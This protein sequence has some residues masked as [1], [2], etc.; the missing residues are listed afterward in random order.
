MAAEELQACWNCAAARGS[1]AMPPDE[2][3]LPLWTAERW[4]GSIGISSVLAQALRPP[5]ETPFDLDPQAQLFFLKEM[6]LQANGKK[7]VH[8]L[9]NLHAIL[10]KLA[11]VIFLGAKT[12]LAATAASGEELNSKF[13]D[14]GSFIM[15]YGTLPDFFGGLESLIGSPNP[16]LMETM[17]D[18][19]MDRMDS[20]A[21]WTTGN[22]GIET[23]PRTEWMF[24]MEP[25]SQRFWPRETKASRHP[26]K[27]RSLDERLEELEKINQELERLGE[28]KMIKE[29]LIGLVLYTGPMFE[30][31]NAVNRGGALHLSQSERLKKEFEDNC[32]GNRYTT[33]IHVINSGII[34]LSKLTKASRVYRG[35]RQGLLPPQFWSADERGSRGG[36]EF[37]F[38]STTTSKAVALQYTRG[39]STPTV[40]EMQMGMIDRGAD[41]SRLSQYPEEREICFPPLTGM[42][43]ID[44]RVEGSVLV[45]QVRLNVNFTALTIDQ[46]LT[47]RHKVIKDMCENLKSEA[48]RELGGEAWEAY[49]AEVQ[50]LA[51]LEHDDEVPCDDDNF[52]ELQRKERLR[53]KRLPQRIREVQR[54]IDAA[55]DAASAKLVS[56]AAERFKAPVVAQPRGIGRAAELFGAPVLQQ[57]RQLRD[58]LKR[59]VLDNANN[60]L[61]A[62][63]SREAGEF[64]SD[65]V[66]QA[67]IREALEVAADVRVHRARALE[68]AAQVLGEASRQPA[69]RKIA[70]A[71]HMMMELPESE[72]RERVMELV[73]EGTADQVSLGPIAS[74]LQ[75]FLV[76]YG[77]L[78]G[79]KLELSDK[80]MG[81]GAACALSKFLVSNATLEELRLDYNPGLGKE[82]LGSVA[83][84]GALQ[85]NRTLKQL[86][87]GGCGISAAGAAALAGALHSN[88]SLEE[89]H[90]SVNPDVG[91]AGAA[92]LGEALRANRVL[93]VLWLSSCGVGDDGAR[94]LAAGLRGNH[95][96]ETL[97]L[98]GNPLL[99]EEG[100]AAL[101]VALEG[102]GVLKAL[103]LH[104]CGVAVDGAAAQ[105]LRDQL[106]SWQ[107]GTRQG[108]AL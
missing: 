70:R 2:T 12:L 22:Y 51:A 65:E 50:N 78:I 16:K 21:K 38:M 4:F 92:A 75:R 105:R 56:R 13:A 27:A 1:N 82:D 107:R 40:L 83:L 30:K 96:L 8:D 102:T 72:A 101:A 86:R 81:Q 60:K 87:L 79:K 11:D 100:A 69:E 74:A 43:V 33:T 18:E 103:W 71:I 89:L 94:A 84:A 57:A 63:T 36:V 62:I 68:A 10:G 61:D 19:H 99:G 6:A 37:G 95:T 34:K 59:L 85:V 104:A 46:V 66:L 91:E 45:V 98:A 49:F 26:R 42:E 54:R 14:S 31:Y 88:A 3:K 35:M 67:A 29:E 39:G 5:H 106:G 90:L 44:T 47:K 53:H 55:Q 23:C 7:M 77:H 28:V 76:L 93:K 64:N 20:E 73:S 108:L 58:S 15:S 17:C 32:L 52:F 41:L 97:G 80:N 25:D 48:E 9:L 24:I